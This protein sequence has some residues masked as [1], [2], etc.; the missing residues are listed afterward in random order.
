MDLTLH[1]A[2]FPATLE[3]WYIDVLLADGAI[4]I[5]YFGALTLFG[6]RMARVTAEYH[7]T[8]GAVARGAAVARRTGGGEDWLRFG[9]A[10]I[11][12]DR[13]RFSLDGVSGDLVYHPRWPPIALREPFLAR[14]SQNLHWIV[15]VPD[16]D[17]TGIIRL[18]DGQRAV[19]GRGYRDRVWY[20]PSLRRFPI[21]ELI[22]GRA[23]AG[24]HAATW[25]RATT[26]QEI[27]AAAW[28]DGAMVAPD[29]SSGPPAG[30][31]LGPARVF[32]DVDV[33]DLNGLRLGALRGP[34]QRLSG[35]PHEI[36]WQA[37]CEIAGE[38]GVAVHE[39]VR[40]R[41]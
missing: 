11:E 18:P 10:S 29:A 5:V 40:W 37:P 38:R 19:E 3:K 14:E 23:A 7:P 8:R 35:N 17:V 28:C 34:L 32:T 26:A 13:F 27:I 2:R 41:V 6:A 4:L 1:P 30:I 31:T 22:W 21:R 9:P 33:A 24:S 15:E 36:K 25:V 16:A 20:N 39:V 12:G